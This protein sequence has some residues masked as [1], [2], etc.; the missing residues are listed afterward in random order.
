VTISGEETLILVSDY[1]VMGWVVSLERLVGIP[2]KEVPLWFAVHS[3]KFNPTYERN[4]PAL[5]G[6]L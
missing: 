6:S 3:G 4:S 5:G 2:A 1:L